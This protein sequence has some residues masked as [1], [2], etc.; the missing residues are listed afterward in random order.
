MN[1]S[2]KNEIKKYISNNYILMGEVYLKLSSYIQETSDPVKI[3]NIQEISAYVKVHEILLNQ[4]EEKTSFENV[5][6]VLLSL[7]NIEAVFK[8]LNIVL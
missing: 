1:D 4:L 2:Q 8:S 5:N 6:N 7:K 3:N